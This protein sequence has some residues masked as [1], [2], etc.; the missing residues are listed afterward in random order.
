MIYSFG[1]LK[2]FYL[3]HLPNVNRGHIGK[4]ESESVLVQNTGRRATYY[5]AI[6][7]PGRRESFLLSTT[8]Q[9]WRCPLF[10][11]PVIGRGQL[12]SR[13][14]SKCVGLFPL[15]FLFYPFAR[16][17]GGRIYELPASVFAS[18]LHEPGP[19]AKREILLLL[20]GR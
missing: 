11:S 4:E 3:W 6:V 7:Q 9:P 12:F 19:T 2:C 16:P 17:W 8:D 14:L 10:R 1:K 13:S 15:F 5:K 18:R 20:M